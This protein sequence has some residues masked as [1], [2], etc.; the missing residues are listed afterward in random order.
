MEDSCLNCGNEFERKN[1]GFNRKNI[2][3]TT[4]IPT[5]S[6]RKI[7]ATTLNE[8]I[9]PDNKLFICGKCASTCCKIYNFHSSHEEFNAAKSASSYLG[10]RKR[11]PIPTASTPSKNSVNVSFPVTPF[12]SPIRKKSNTSTA[13]SNVSSSK[14]FIDNAIIHLKNYKYYT[15][16][17][18]LLS[19]SKAAR[20]SLRKIVVDNVCKEMKNINEHLIPLSS[21][22]AQESLNDFNWKNCLEPVESQLPILSAAVKTALA[23]KKSAH[24]LSQ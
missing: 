23:P 9:T 19:R 2:D 3:S 21:K 11:T 22:L 16:F 24:K 13:S 10:K 12:S 5:V 14:S 7:L 8:P 1:K 18:L 20:E 15:A 4:K 17:R 6:F